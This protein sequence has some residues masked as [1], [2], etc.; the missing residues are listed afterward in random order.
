MKRKFPS[1]LTAYSLTMAVIIVALLAMGP[2][3]SGVAIAQEEQWFF[4]P[5]NGHEYRLTDPMPWVD[6]EAQAVAWGG[7]LVTLNNAE[8]ELW[9][10][11]T[12]GR[13]ELFYI[14]FNDIEEE[15][16][17]VWSSG[18]SITYT[19]WDDSEPNNCCDCTDSPACE[20]AAVMNWDSSDSNYFGNYWNDL[21]PDDNRRGIVERSC[22]HLFP[23]C[24]PGEYRH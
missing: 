20:D 16:I 8:E 4:N 18:A 9:V 6:A 7:H 5:A 12:F 17:W 10:K 23:G 14:G 11:D 24:G 13:L 3:K 15:G 21:S 22:I 19:N 1:I 2:I